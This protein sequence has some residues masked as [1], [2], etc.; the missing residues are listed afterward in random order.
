[1]NTYSIV[2]LPLSDAAKELNSRIHVAENVVFNHYGNVTDKE[3]LEFVETIGDNS[4]EVVNSLV[5]SSRVAI[6]KAMSVFKRKRPEITDCWLTLRAYAPCDHFEIPRF[7]CDG[8]SYQADPETVHTRFIATLVGPGTIMSELKPTPEFNDAG[9]NP[10]NFRK[11]IDAFRTAE[12]DIRLKRQEM[13]GDNYKQLDCNVGLMLACSGD[14]RTIHS[15]PN[16]TEMR[17]LVSLVGGTSKQIK[18]KKMRDRFVPKGW[19]E[20]KPGTAETNKK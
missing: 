1:M 7:H 2:E 20:L 10:H 15:E 16:I 13:I 8:P 14:H 4:P 12:R 6:D 18:E 5:K 19:K 3:I 17:Y 9:K 11:D